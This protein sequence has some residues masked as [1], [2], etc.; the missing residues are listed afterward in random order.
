M[1]NEEDPRKHKRESAE[2]PFAPDAKADLPEDVTE[3]A[4]C[5]LDRI[6]KD[7]RAFWSSQIS[8]LRRE[9]KR[10]MRLATDWRDSSSDA[11]K[12]VRGR[13]TRLFLARI[14]AKP[15]MRGQSRVQH[16]TKGFPAIE[17]I[18]EPGDSSGDNSREQPELEPDQFFRH[19]G[20]RIRARTSGLRGPD[21]VHL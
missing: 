19:V 12:Q 14:L 7:L 4:E 5:N 6:P 3:A 8:E 11:Q 21:A 18:S 9:E 16:F 1:Q 15:D 10:R 13:V 2:V 20:S 17:S